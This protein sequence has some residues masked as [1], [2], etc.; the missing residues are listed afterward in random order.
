MTDTEEAAGPPP[1][2]DAAKKLCSLNLEPNSR[3]ELRLTAT[4]PGEADGVRR[5]MT[6]EILVDGKSLGPVSEVLVTVQ[7]SLHT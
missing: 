2:W 1:G 3:G 5:L 7:E 6:A 4:S